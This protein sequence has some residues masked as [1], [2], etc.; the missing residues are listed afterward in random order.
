MPIQFLLKDRLAGYA[1]TTAGP[2]EKA[3][4]CYRELIGPDDANHLQRQLDNFQRTLFSHIP[5]LHAPS[6]VDHILVVIN[7]D[8]NC[9][10]YVNELTI[11]AKARATRAIEK[12]A[13]VYVE[14]ISEVTSVNIGVEVPRDCAWVLVRST[15][16]RRSLFFDFGPLIPELGARTYSIEPVLAQQAMLLLGLIPSR[17]D[18]G[19]G[20]MPTGLQHM[21]RGLARL[22]QLLAE[23]CEDESAYQ[24]LL[25]GH[26]W[27]FGAMYVEA[28]R[29]LAFDDRSI[30][31][32][33]AVRSYDRCHDIIEL[34]Q[35]FL[36]LFRRDRGF[37]S[38]FNDA[39]NQ[40]ERYLLFAIQQR[41]YLSE[42]KGLRFENPRCILVLGCGL[43]TSQVHEIRKK[44]SFNRAISVF[45]YDDLV[46]AAS[47]IVQ[48][49]QTAGER[50]VPN[51]AIELANSVR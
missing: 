47:H 29:H 7:P 40:A 13:P 12:G 41:T 27:M 48:L 36:K 18:R 23:R 3:Q 8:L 19:D 50:V 9:T 46:E 33:T 6:L 20:Q 51:A 43:E 32:F 28:Q 15:G 1:T 35:P 21:E 25:S 14:D 24:A 2:G 4:I 45:T 16:W 5:G 31:D 26:P 11:R 30:P 22:R 17:N 34:K 44:E 38:E 49:A 39:W 10:A 42:E 37:S